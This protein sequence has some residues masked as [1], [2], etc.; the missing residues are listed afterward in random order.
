MGQ[1]RHGEASAYAAGTLLYNYWAQYCAEESS[2]IGATSR[3]FQQPNFA[4]DAADLVS[5]V[6]CLRHPATFSFS[7]YSG[8]APP[9]LEPW[10]DPRAARPALNTRM[11]Q[12]PDSRGCNGGS[13]H[14]TGPYA[15]DALAVCT[16]PAIRIQ[17]WLSAGLRGTAIV[18]SRWI[19]NVL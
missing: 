5:L 16:T 2:S 6:H 4:L 10:L 12:A 17:D 3:L 19:V 18:T 11:V 1:S 15:L 7:V 13:N 14:Q 9:P 8:L